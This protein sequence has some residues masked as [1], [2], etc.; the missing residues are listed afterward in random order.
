MTSA[1]ALTNT[2]N[3]CFIRHSNKESSLQDMPDWD[4]FPFAYGTY[5]T[6]FPVSYYP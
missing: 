3:A 2:K 6:E 1:C 4:E 5:I